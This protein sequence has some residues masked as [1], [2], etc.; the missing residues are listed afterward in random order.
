MA[1]SFEVTG[2]PGF[3]KLWSEEAKPEETKRDRASDTERALERVDQIGAEARL[4]AVQ[5]SRVKAWHFSQERQMDH[6]RSAASHD[7]PRGTTAEMESERESERETKSERAWRPSQ[8]RQRRQ[9]QQ[10]SKTLA[11]AVCGRNRAPR[12]FARGDRTIGH[13]RQRTQH[14]MRNGCPAARATSSLV[15]CCLLPRESVESVR[16]RR[17]RTAQRALKSKKTRSA[18]MA[19]RSGQTNNSNAMTRPSAG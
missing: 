1:R 11:V 19:C 4:A 13:V 14:S 18:S 3:S 16:R 6:R 12:G 10:S 15:C 17:R 8:E 7:D 2:R 5:T 9:Q